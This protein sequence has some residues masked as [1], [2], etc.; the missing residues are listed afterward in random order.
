MKIKEIKEN[1]HFETL[2]E[3]HDL[4][5]FDCG[6]E[7]LNDFLKKRCIKSTKREFKYYKTSNVQWQNHGICF[8]IN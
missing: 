3:N 7:D 8:I 1:Y 4:S 5:D 2:N 6:D